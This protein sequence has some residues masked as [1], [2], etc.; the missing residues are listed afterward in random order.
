MADTKMNAGVLNPVLIGFTAG[1]LSTVVFHQAALWVLWRIGWAAF[2][3]YVMADVPPF[4]IPAVISLAFWG[5]LWGIVFAL[6]HHRFP[7]TV[8]WLSAFLFGAVLPSLVAFFIV[9]PLK[10]RPVAGGWQIPL[11]TTAVFIN[12]MWGLGT[13]VFFNLLRSRFQFRQVRRCPPGAVCDY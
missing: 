12:G 2:P 13:G 9:A 10:G 3:P 11:L 5:G 7:R 4:G 1:F 8:Y 6:T